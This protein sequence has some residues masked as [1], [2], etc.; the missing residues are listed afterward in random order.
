M[1]IVQNIATMFLMTEEESIQTIRSIIF[2]YLPEDEYNSFIF[3]SRAGKKAREWSDF[4]IGIKGKQKVPLSTLGLI[5]ED[6]ENSRIPY[7][8]DVVDFSRVPE[9]FKKVAQKKTVKL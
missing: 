9:K 2:K 5:K 3:G 8:V 1:P 6:L 7:K 4:D